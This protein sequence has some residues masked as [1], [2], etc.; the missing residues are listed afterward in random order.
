MVNRSYNTLWL[1]SQLA[2]AVSLCGSPSRE[3]GFNQ[4]DP[5]ST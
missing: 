3:A 2:V 4:K 5:R 1:I